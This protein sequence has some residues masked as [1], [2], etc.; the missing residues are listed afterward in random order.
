MKVELPGSKSH[1]HRAVICAALARGESVIRNPLI[2]QDT[3]HTISALEAMGVK[4]ERG[5]GFIMVRGTELKAPNRKLFLGNSGTSLRLLLSISALYDGD[6]LLEGVPRLHKRPIK[7]LIKALEKWGVEVEEGRPIRVKGKGFIKGGKTEVDCS[8]SS[9]FL[10]S[11]LLV[12]PYTLEGGEITVKGG[13]VSRGYVGI[14]VEVMKAFGVYVHIE[15]DTYKVGR[16]SYKPTEFTIPVDASSATY[17]LAASALTGLEIDLYGP[18]GTHPDWGF[19]EILEKMGCKVY[20]E[21]NAVKVK[22]G[23]LTGLEISMRDMPDAV[24]TLAVL[25]AF[26]NGETVIKDVGHLRGKESD[27]ISVLLQNLNAI[28]VKAKVNGESLIV[29]GG[30]A[31]GGVVDPHGDHR[32]AMAFAVAGLIAPIEVTDRGCVE[33]SFPGFWDILER[34]REE[35]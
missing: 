17:F 1:T 25:G 2:C 26:A 32:I 3:I 23:E 30:G 5:R 14:T 18:F 6:V 27:R 34:F 4:I 16:E 22:G 15:E 19:L 9:Q 28:G 31:K 29:R 10:S 11:L 33:K 35:L 7:P 20:R 21:E 8:L 13:F 12:S 24:P